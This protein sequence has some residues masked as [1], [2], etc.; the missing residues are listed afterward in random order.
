MSD[1]ERHQ[2]ALLLRRCG[3]R[4]VI[5]AIAVDC[6]RQAEEAA[7]EGDFRTER[8]WKRYADLFSAIAAL[9]PKQNLSTE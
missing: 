2:V 7:E 6:G 9:T 1:D 8:N 4:A 5:A 3:L